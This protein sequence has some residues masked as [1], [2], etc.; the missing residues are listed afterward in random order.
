MMRAWVMERFGP[1]DVLQLRD[2]V[3]IPDPG[4]GEVRVRVHAIAVARTK[5]V[6]MRAGNPPFAPRVSLPHTPGTEHA[7][8]VDAVGTDVDPDR[9]GTRVAVSAVLSCGACAACVRGHE[10]ACATFGLIGVD[11]AGSYG[12]YVVVP[13]GNVHAIPDGL[14]FTHAAS[15]AA[16]GGVARAQLDAGGVGPGT[17]VAVMGAAGALGSTAATLAKHRGA[18]VFAVD[19]L[20]RKKDVLDALPFDAVFDGGDPDLAAQLRAR[21][22]GWGVDCVID[23]L[24][25]APLWAGYRPAVATLGRIVV[26]GAIG[27]DPIPMELLPFYL[28]SQSLLGVRTGNIGQVRA[29]WDDV[30]A[31]FRLA[32]SAVVA[33]PWTDM[34]EVHAMVEE[35]RSVGQTV[36][37][38][39]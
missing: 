17:I 12:E 25:L 13:V 35:G 16:N 1:P 36:A 21:T 32:D 19:Q 10:E 30:R 8:I 24:G 20:G 9:V 2:D 22:D 4:P 18:T 37:E 34:H 5:D 15:L 29:L 33:R 38:V 39:G 14:S 27:R 23:N 31:G 7:G 6:A 28:H 3:P 11:R 26:S